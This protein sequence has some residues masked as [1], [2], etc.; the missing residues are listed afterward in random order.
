MKEFWNNEIKST[1]YVKGPPG[2]GK[3]CFL[4]LWAR[5]RSVK[6]NKRVLIVQFRPKDCFIWI[7]EAGGA[8]WRMDKLIGPSDLFGEVDA[9]L[10]NNEVAKTPFDLCIHDGVVDRDVLSKTYWAI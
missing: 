9:F 10:D 1:L 2:C 5:F 6:D 7:R 8:L 4:Y 3:T